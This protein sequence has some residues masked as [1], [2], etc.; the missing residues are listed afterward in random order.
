MAD[1]IGDSPV[2]C[3]SVDTE[4][5]G[6]TVADCH[7]RGRD[8]EEWLVNEGWAMAYRRYSNDYIP[9]EQEAKNNRRGIWSGS[10]KPP[11]EWRKQQRE[12]HLEPLHP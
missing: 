10:L 7:V 6:R 5:Y 12:S 9:A 2:S 1:F 8:I 11:W 3:Q 4:R